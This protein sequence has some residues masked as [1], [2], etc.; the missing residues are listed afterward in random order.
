MLALPG[1]GRAQQ[2][3]AN[4]RAV[5]T[6]PGVNIDEAVRMPNGRVILYI[7]YGEVWGTIY[8]YDIASKRSTKV[9]ASVDGD[10]TISPVGDRIAFER[11]TEDGHNDFIATMPIDP[12]TGFSAG[13]AQRLSLGLADHPNFSPDGR[14]IAFRSQSGTSD[15]IVVPAS[16][17]PERTLAK[18][19]FHAIPIA[20]SADGKWV[21]VR[22]DDEHRAP[23]AI[24]RVPVQGGAKVTEFPFGVSDIASLNQGIAFYQDAR[25]RGQRAGR[26]S[27]VTP[28]G[29][30]GDFNV[31]PQSSPA[32]AVSVESALTL[33]MAVTRPYTTRMLDLTSGAVRDLL[34]DAKTSLAAAWSPDGRR[35]AVHD[36]TAGALGI[37]VINSDGSQPR[38]YAAAPRPSGALM[39]WSPSGRTLAYSTGFGPAAGVSTGIALLDIA[40]GSSRVIAAPHGGVGF[41]ATG[42]IWR[43]DSKSILYVRSA[44]QP[45]GAR[46]V[47]EVGL[48]GA[49]HKLRDIG[50][51]FAGLNLAFISDQLIALGNGQPETQRVMATSGGPPRMLP[52]GVGK[53]RTYLGASPDRR[54]LAFLIRDS[55]RRTTGVELMTNTGDSL[56]T[57]PLTFQADW[58]KRAEFQPDGR[59]LVMVGKHAG[60]TASTIYLVPLGGGAPRAVARVTDAIA[61]Y[62]A[63][64]PDGRSVVFATSGTPTSVLYEL[65]VSPIVQALAKR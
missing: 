24:D 58:T 52:P 47:V 30:H 2:P 29:A 64:S 48:D 3:K 51:D 16:G 8:A 6:F 55:D 7:T 14:L 17:G 38:R 10:I 15:I 32:S 61:G 53:T 49:D 22:V 46:E 28:S 54:W 9:T 34:P 45:A 65:D 63:L 19:P 4:V 50:A 57:V 20:W 56:R 26:M 60:D 43:P 35:V 5:A 11:G 23:T 39:L 31:P 42:F 59:H 62:L 1:G 44:A 18:Y 21:I 13:P 12:A 27:Y 25:E 36:S 40:T 33:L 41:A 37:T